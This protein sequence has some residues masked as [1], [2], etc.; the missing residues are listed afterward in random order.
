MR[1]VTT[2]PVS[3]PV[4]AFPSGF[5]T[6]AL[7]VSAGGVAPSRDW[8]STSTS[9][10]SFFLGSAVA[11]GHLDRRDH[12]AGR[13]PSPANPSAVPLSTGSFGTG[14]RAA[15]GGFGL[16]FFGA[17]AL[18]ALAVELVLGASSSLRVTA[19]RMMPQPFIS[20]LE[21]PG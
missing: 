11:G 15:V 4:A 2:V 8:T 20:L 7:G 5:H 16:F 6:A 3:L 17:A 21:R 19:R 14:G 10:A 13:G 18:L 9:L 1:H 12:G